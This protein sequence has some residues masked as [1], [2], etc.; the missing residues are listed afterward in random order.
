MPADTD[1]RGPFKIAVVVGSQRVVRICPQVSQFVLEVIKSHHASASAAAG[2]ELPEL[3]IALLD[4]ATF[5]LP[6]TDETGMPAHVEDIPYGYTTEATRAW[7]AAVASFDAFVF[8][9]PQ[10]N[11]SWGMPAALKNALD[12]LFHEWGGKPAMVVTY[13]GF[14]GTFGAAALIT[15]LSGLFMRVVKRAVCMKYPDH[16]FIGRAVAGE[17]LG[18]DSKNEEGLWADQKAGII[19]LWEEVLGMLVAGPSKPDLRS[20]G[21][22]DLWEEMLAPVAGIEKMRAAAS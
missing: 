5:A 11:A 20:A 21:L 16:A 18:L 22:Q 2:A 14:G 1:P 12:H 7:S 10:Y 17:D 13:G 19:E 8:V 15:V 6:L 4:I 9:A 3:D